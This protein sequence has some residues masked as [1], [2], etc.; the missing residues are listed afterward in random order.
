MHRNR[1]E[2]PDDDDELEKP[3]RTPSF[4]T[5]RELQAKHTPKAGDEQHGE[6][7]PARAKAREKKTR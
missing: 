4:L 2:R 7:G 5:A 6:E 1:N 3:E